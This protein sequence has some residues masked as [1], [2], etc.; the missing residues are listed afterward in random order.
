MKKEIII[1]TSEGLALYWIFPCGLE[2]F[3][4]YL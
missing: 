4:K 3:A 2:V 1:Q